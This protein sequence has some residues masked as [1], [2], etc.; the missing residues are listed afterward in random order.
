[1][2]PFEHIIGVV[3]RQAISQINLVSHET[4]WIPV[5]RISDFVVLL[6]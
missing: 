4:I 2:S 5:E 3:I 6:P 1:M